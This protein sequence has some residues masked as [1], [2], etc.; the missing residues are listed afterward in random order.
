LWLPLRSWHWQHPSRIAIPDRPYRSEINLSS[1]P[2][3]DDAGGL[4]FALGSI[5]LRL[6]SHRV[7]RMAYDI[8]PS[9]FWLPTAACP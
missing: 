8:F 3:R 2:I 9:P 5:F 4:L 6:L 7:H 1:I